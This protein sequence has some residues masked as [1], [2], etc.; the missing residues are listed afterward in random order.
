VIGLLL[1]QSLLALSSFLHRQPSQGHIAVCDVLCLLLRQG[2]LA[3]HGF[4]R[5]QLR[6]GLFVLH[7]AACCCV[8]QPLLPFSSGLRCHASQGLLL[9]KPA[10]CN[11]F[12]EGL[13]VV[14]HAGR[15]LRQGLVEVHR[16]IGLLLSQSLLALS[17]FLHRQPSQGH[18]AVCDVLC[19]LLRQGLLA[20]HGFLR[21]QL[22]QGLFVLH[23]AACCCVSQPLLPFSSGLRCHASQGLLLIKPA[24]CNSFCESLLVVLHSGRLLRQG[25]YVG[26]F[27]LLGHLQRSVGGRLRSRPLVAKH[28][29][30]LGDTDS[31]LCCGFLLRSAFHQEARRSLICDRCE[32][33]AHLLQLANLFLVLRSQFPRHQILERGQFL[34]RLRLVHLFAQLCLQRHRR[35]LDSSRPLLFELRSELALE[36]LLVPPGLQCGRTGGLAGSPLVLELRG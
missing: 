33:K 17:S 4:L 2:L 27:P 8:S 9:I 29:G 3:P 21:R 34:R 19:L 16:V 11:L 35:H 25:L 18:I 7:V 24:L 12:C 32:L 23:V 30:Q 14:L 26:P 31:R 36:P 10:L 1:S 5:R 15:L 20:P 28:F 13:L 6:Q 22:R